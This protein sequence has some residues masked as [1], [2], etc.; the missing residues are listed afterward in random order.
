MTEIALSL[1][2]IRVSKVKLTDKS[3]DPAFQ[4]IEKAAVIRELLKILKESKDPLATKI[5]N[6]HAYLAK[7][8]DHVLRDAILNQNRNT[9]GHRMVMLFNRLFSRPERV[10]NR[11][12]AILTLFKQLPTSKSKD[13]EEKKEAEGEG[14]GEKG[15]EQHPQE[16][17]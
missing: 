1:S 15:K 17:L 8:E 13:T 7:K 3:T 10:N 6:A 12:A 4:A 16:R 14:E 9:I 2:G 11:G 5:Q